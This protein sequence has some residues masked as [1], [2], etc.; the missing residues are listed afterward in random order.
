MTHDLYYLISVISAITAITK[1]HVETKLLWNYIYCKNSLKKNKY[2]THITHKPCVTLLFS[3]LQWVCAS[4]LHPAEGDTA[5][6]CCWTR[7]QR[8]WGLFPHFWFKPPHMY[9][10]CS[11]PCLVFQVI[12][13]TTRIWEI[14]GYRA[15]L[16]LQS[17]S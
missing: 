9:A 12:H 1:M 11:W 3:V 8:F 2:F 17:H 4:T 5:S 6:R 14:W 10:V 15:A 7:Q 13:E 16:L